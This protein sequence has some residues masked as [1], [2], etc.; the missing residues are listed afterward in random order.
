MLPIGLAGFLTW[1][2]TLGSEFLMGFLPLFFFDVGSSTS[3]FGCEE[4]I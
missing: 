1:I 4:P 3:S 2:L